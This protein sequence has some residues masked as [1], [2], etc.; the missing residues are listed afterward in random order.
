MLYH[1]SYNQ[2]LVVLGADGF[3]LLVTPA[4]DKPVLGLKLVPARRGASVPNCPLLS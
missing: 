4:N 2:C 1:L 3:D